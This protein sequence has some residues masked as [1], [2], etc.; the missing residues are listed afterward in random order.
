LRN[1]IDE[2]PVSK[3]E[4]YEESLSH[5]R[6]GKATLGDIAKATGMMQIARKTGLG[7]ERLHLEFSPDI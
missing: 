6:N 5:V 3:R 4:G 1:W 2:Y 7:R